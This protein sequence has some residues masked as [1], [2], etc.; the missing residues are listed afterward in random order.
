VTDFLR[1]QGIPAPV[2]DGSA[3]IEVQD[4]G[5]VMR[6]E[7]GTL[8]RDRV[9]VKRVWTLN[10]V[11]QTPANAMAWIDW[12]LGRKSQVWSFE[13]H[14]YS[15]KGFAVGTTGT[16]GVSAGQFGFS[17]SVP[18]STTVTVNDSY[19]YSAGPG[20][21]ASFWWFNGTTWSHIVETSTNV[22]YINGVASGARTFCTT[23]PTTLTITNPDAAVRRIDDL[24]VSF[25]VWP[26]TWPAAVFASGQA[27]GPSPRL[28]VDGLLI[29]NNTRALNVVAEVTGVD[30]AQASV[31]G[32]WVANIQRVKLKLSEV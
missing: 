32:A 3:S 5:E 22:K 4:I 1:I 30:I 2:E 17:L 16:P 27:L 19:N 12:V 9:D 31:S 21:S 18:A 11:L 14:V 15:S 10:L 28:T 8:I 13:S 20:W 7:D 25:F 6:A 24:C 29:D 23:S 26:S